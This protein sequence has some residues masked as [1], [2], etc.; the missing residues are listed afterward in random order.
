MINPLEITL[1]NQ[2]KNHVTVQGQEDTWWKRSLEAIPLMTRCRAE[3]WEC[4]LERAVTLV[5]FS[6]GEIW[7]LLKIIFWDPFTCVQ[8]WGKSDLRKLQAA[9][10][11]GSGGGIKSRFLPTSIISGKCACTSRFLFQFHCWSCCRRKPQIPA[12]AA[13]FVLTGEKEESAV[14]KRNFRRRERLGRQQWRGGG[15]HSGEKH[16]HS[17]TRGWDSER[18]GGDSWGAG[19]SWGLC[20]TR[21][22][23][24][25]AVFKGDREILGH[26]LLPYFSPFLF[27]FWGEESSRRDGERKRTV[28][29]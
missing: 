19:A 5:F 15:W 22:R 25:P 10:Q 4:I 2:I 23:L 9:N 8:A 26:V 7:K 16:T 28:K 24:P 20:P 12:A 17:K 6:P 27:P 13:A 14:E 1:A 21:L 11:G 18:K 3:K 29:F